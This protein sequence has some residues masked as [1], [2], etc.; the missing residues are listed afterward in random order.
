MGSLSKES[1]DEFLDSLKQAG[2][3]ISNEAELRAR[4][5][6]VSH[7]RYAFTTLAANGSQLGIRFRDRS[8][9]RNSEAIRRAFAD[10]HF[11][12]N[13]EVIFAASLKTDN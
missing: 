10:Y 8:Q 5:G 9:G 3:D 12:A 2:I 11:A 4:L 13:S 1:C 6:E 7:W